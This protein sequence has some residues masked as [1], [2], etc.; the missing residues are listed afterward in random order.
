MDRRTLLGCVGA[1]VLVSGG[2]CLGDV[3]SGTGQN[4]LKEKDF[5]EKPDP[6]TKGSATGFVAEYEEVWMHNDMLSE[7]TTKITVGCPA[8]VDAEADGGYYLITIC[9]GSQTID[10]EGSEAVGHLGP[11]PKFYFVSD[12]SVQRI[13]TEH[14]KSE[15]APETY[16]N[17]TGGR[18]VQGF[19]LVNFDETS[20]EVT[21]TVTHRKENE[22]IFERTYDLVSE[23][24]LTRSG[25]T[26]VEGIYDLTVELKTGESATYE[27]HIDD[28]RPPFGVNIY[29]SRSGAIHFGR[30]T[31][32]GM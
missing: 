9:R 32:P 22:T 7:N 18:E 16:G 4:G 27:W 5:P 23:S 21:V 17:G 12:D 11:K 19:R 14:R 6:V 24:L 20:H 15:P 30:N 1:T 2:G 26:A 31:D 28:I 3:G 25:L 29:I 10:R 8:A 13:D